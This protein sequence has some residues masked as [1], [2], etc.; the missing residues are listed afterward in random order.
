[1]WERLGRPREACAQWI[2]AARWRNQADDP[3]WKRSVACV[4]RDAGAGDWRDIRAYALGLAPPERR[5][6]LAAEA[7]C[8]RPASPDAASNRD[9]RHPPADCGPRRRHRA[10]RRGPVRLEVTGAE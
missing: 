9:R 6:A 8:G 3:A 7:G 1:V 4:R 10:E 5:E 2:R